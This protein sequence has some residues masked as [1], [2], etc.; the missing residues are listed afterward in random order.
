[1]KNLQ[2]LQKTNDEL[3]AKFEGFALTAEEARMVQ[4]GNATT[5]TSGEGDGGGGFDLG[6]GDTGGGQDEP[7]WGWWKD[8][9]GVSHEL[10]QHPTTGALSFK[11]SQGVMQPFT[12]TVSFVRWSA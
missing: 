8:A 5:I 10:W 6:G 7:R 2:N 1:M 3:F 9:N 4:G 12:A 11:D